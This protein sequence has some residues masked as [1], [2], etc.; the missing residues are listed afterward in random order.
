MADPAPGEHSGAVSKAQGG[1]LSASGLATHPSPETVR[2]LP[3]STGLGRDASNI[4]HSPS[5]GRNPH[6]GKYQYKA[7]H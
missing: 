1:M 3:H 2:S 6:S 4:R 7:I 5:P